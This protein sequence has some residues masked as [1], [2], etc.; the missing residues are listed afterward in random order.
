MLLFPSV[1]S[2]AHPPPLFPPPHPAYFFRVLYD[3]FLWRQKACAA[4]AAVFLQTDCSAS[5]AARFTLYLCSALHSLAF[6]FVAACSP[7]PAFAR[8]IIFPGSGLLYLF[9]L[10]LLLFGSSVTTRTYTIVLILPCLLL[11]LLTRLCCSSRSFLYSLLHQ[12]ILCCYCCRLV[13]E[14]L[15]VV[16]PQLLLS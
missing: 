6:G 10:L 8:L 3:S 4:V 14:K 11:L 5:I 7:W 1:N 9:G 16:R 13:T 2:I 12:L 15:L